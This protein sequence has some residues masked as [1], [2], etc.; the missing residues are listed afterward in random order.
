MKAVLNT[1]LRM[2][3]HAFPCATTVCC[4]TAVLSALICAPRGMPNTALM[5]NLL[6]RP[7]T[8]IRQHCVFAHH[9]YSVYAADSVFNAFP[10]RTGMLLTLSCTC[11]ETPPA[12]IDA[13]GGTCSSRISNLTRLELLH[14]P[15]TLQCDR[16]VIVHSIAPSTEPA[17]HKRTVQAK[18][19]R[20][21]ESSPTPVKQH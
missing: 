17:G 13:K 16:F 1:P 10:A 14:Q 21:S 3:H 6:S 9:Q 2:L 8:Q 15:I 5:R 4:S 18:P 12:F 11:I 20:T 7:E 19:G